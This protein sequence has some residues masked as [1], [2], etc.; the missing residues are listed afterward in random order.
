VVKLED[1]TFYAMVTVY[2]EKGEVHYIDARP[3]DSIALALKTKAPI[4]VAEE[5]MLKAAISPE[6]MPEVDLELLTELN[7]KLQEAVANEEYEEA[8]KL[9]DKIQEL[10]KKMG[11]RNV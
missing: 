5:V 4:F 3:S 2:D 6:Q 1:N 8:A 7:R 11:G 10:E 9:R